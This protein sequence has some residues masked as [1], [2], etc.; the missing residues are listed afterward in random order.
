LFCFRD[1]R[2]PVDI[3]FTDR[4]GGTSAAPFDSLN[5]GSTRFDPQVEANV[6]LVAEALGTAPDRLARM[7]QVH[8][9]D[10][11]VVRDV[12]T[13][14]A[15]PAADGMVTDRPDLTLAVRVADCVPVLLADAAAGIIGCAHAGRPGLVAG[16]VP[17]TVASMRHLGARSVVAWMGPHVC[18]ACYEV[19]A[20]MRSAVGDVVPEA[21]STTSWGTPALDIGAG[22]RAQLALAGCEVVDMARCTREAADLYSYRR[23]GLNAGRFAGL[24]RLVAPA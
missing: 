8:G 23:D 14:A 20:R 18:G 21:K 6:A 10:V 7:N 19:P 4:H 13:G 17:A 22:V 16:I 24:I 1:S 5:L 15:R 11:V 3:A 9:A 2:G 12:A